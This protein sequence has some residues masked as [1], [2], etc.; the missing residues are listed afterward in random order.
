MRVITPLTSLASDFYIYPFATICALLAGGA[1]PRTS[2]GG[3]TALSLATASLFPNV[4]QVVNI[5]IAQWSLIVAANTSS[6]QSTH[7]AASNHN[8]NIDTLGAN[9]MFY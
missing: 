8:I 9:S 4:L 7:T 5:T 1:D 2:N 3:I 6:V